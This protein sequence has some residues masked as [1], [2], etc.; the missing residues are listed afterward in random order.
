MHSSHHMAPPPSRVASSSTCNSKKH[1]VPPDQAGPNALLDSDCTA[2]AQSNLSDDVVMGSPPH[3]W[4]PRLRTERQILRLPAAPLSMS[5]SHVN[6][7]LS[8]SLSVRLHVQLSGATGNT[9]A[10]CP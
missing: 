8:L 10:T 9:S 7:S 4:A 2:R 3:P 1:K 5:M 6:A